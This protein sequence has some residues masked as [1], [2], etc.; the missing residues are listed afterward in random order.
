M[1]EIKEV[2]VSSALSM[3]RIYS[4]TVL[5][6]AEYV[7]D[8]FGRNYMFTLI[9]PVGVGER[10]QTAKHLYDYLGVF[11]M[12]KFEAAHP[13][14]IEHNAINTKRTLYPEAEEAHK[15]MMALLVE[16]FGDSQKMY[17]F[18]VNLRDRFGGGYGIQ[19]T[20]LSVLNEVGA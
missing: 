9:A 13:D 10:F 5:G 16:E 3:Q 6:T 19:E 17:T 11:V 7:F 2:S 14:F 8:A 4:R 20:V 1:S 12:A 15:R 18:G